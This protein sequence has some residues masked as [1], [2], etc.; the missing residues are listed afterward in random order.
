MTK[1]TNDSNKKHTTKKKTK[2][3]TQIGNTELHTTNRNQWERQ[4]EN[5]HKKRTEEQQRTPTTEKG[6][7]T[8]ETH[9]MVHEKKKK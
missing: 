3:S 9:E 6:T 4:G 5:K 1:Q 2:N 7:C 8:R